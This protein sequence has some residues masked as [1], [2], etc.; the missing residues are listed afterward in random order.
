MGPANRL[1]Q[2][3]PGNKK[4]DAGTTI[5]EHHLKEEPMSKEQSKKTETA[6]RRKFLAG[7]AAATARAATLGLP[8]IAK[9]PGPI[10]MRWQSTWASEDVFHQYTLHLGQK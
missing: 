9:G 5:H 3:V 2:K 7:A 1:P 6:S 8:M 4:N 10:S